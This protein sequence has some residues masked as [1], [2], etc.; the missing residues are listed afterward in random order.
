M[1]IFDS[2]SNWFFAMQCTIHA[3][4]GWLRHEHDFRQ[5]ESLPGGDGMKTRSM[6]P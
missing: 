2:N 5:S 1:Q 4:A 3:G 6:E